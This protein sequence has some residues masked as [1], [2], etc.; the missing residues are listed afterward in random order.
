MLQPASS[1]HEPVTN[2]HRPAHLIPITSRTQGEPTIEDNVG[3]AT[4]RIHKR[5]PLASPIT[6]SNHES[7]VVCRRHRISWI[8]PAG[9]VLHRRSAV[10][11]SISYRVLIPP[12]LSSTPNSR[13]G[14]DGRRLQSCVRCLAN[15]R[16]PSDTTIS[17]SSSSSATPV[18][19]S[20]ACCCDSP[21]THTPSRT[22]RPS[23]LISYVDVARL[24]C[25]FRSRC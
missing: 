10:A 5:P 24:S 1:H 18:L 9:R 12:Q 11:D 3:K 20:R 16:P 19:E 15:S 22:S 25:L 4:S 8:P 23:A 7:R 6:A 13:L 17:S 21:T 14:F 2:R